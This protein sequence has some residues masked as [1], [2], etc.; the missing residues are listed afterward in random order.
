MT[1]YFFP[2]ELRN[3]FV[4]G[5]LKGLKIRN[6]V[7][8]QHFP[9]PVYLL[10][11]AADVERLRERRGRA[12]ATRVVKQESVEVVFYLLHPVQSSGRFREPRALPWCGLR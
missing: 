10:L 6:L 7:L 3:S 8:G 2:W 11:A 1:T 12:G 4:F 9:S 5:I